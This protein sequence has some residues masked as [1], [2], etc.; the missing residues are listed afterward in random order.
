MRI[1]I[2]VFLLLAMGNLDPTETSGQTARDFNNR[3]N[4]WADKKE[5]DRAIADFSEAIRLEPRY[6]LAYSNRG[7]AWLDKEEYD[8]GLA[9]LNRAIQLDPRLSVAYYNR[10]NAWLDKKMLDKAVSDYTEAL[11]L[12]PH[13]AQAYSNRALIWRVKEEYGKA[14]ADYTEAIRIDPKDAR[15]Y[16]G[17]GKASRGRGTR[18]GRL[19]LHQ[20]LQIDSKFIEAYFERGRAFSDKGAFDKAIHDFTEVIRLDPKS[21]EAYLAW[22]FLASQ[23]GARQGHRRLHRSDPTR[24]QVHRGV[25]RYTISRD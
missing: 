20:E 12:D 8:R 21:I 5:Y 1:F 16:F 17:R 22:R 2:P 19:R 3:G 9:D 4:A 10:G 11:R 15:L 23:G 18:Q 6:A 14:V 7:N 24:P 25:S 13:L